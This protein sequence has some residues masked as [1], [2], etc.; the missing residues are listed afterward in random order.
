MIELSGVDD[1]LRPF[2]LTNEQVQQLCNAYATIIEQEPDIL[3]YEFR[4]QKSAKERRQKITRVLAL[5]Q[6]LLATN[7]RTDGEKMQR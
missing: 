1:K 2:E 6:R 7:E 4:S 3:T 5:E